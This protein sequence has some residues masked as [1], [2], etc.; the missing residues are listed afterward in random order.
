MML[1]PS[2]RLLCTLSALVI[3][4]GVLFCT[5]T[6]KAATRSAA[7][8]VVMLCKLL[9]PL[10]PVEAD[11]CATAPTAD[12][13]IDKIFGRRRELGLLRDAAPPAS[14]AAP[15]SPSPSPMPPASAPPAPPASAL[16]SSAPAAAGATAA[17]GKARK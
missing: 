4:S 16:A 3:A 5:P 14:S 17:P 9:P 1:R 6:E 10:D 8:A 13:A 12:A 15:P 2:L 11:I 7:D